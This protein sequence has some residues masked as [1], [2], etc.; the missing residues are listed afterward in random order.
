MWAGRP[1]DARA[2]GDGVDW[3]EPW[4]TLDAPQPLSTKAASRTAGRIAV[5]GIARV[6]PIVDIDELYG[7]PLDRFIP[8]RTALAKQLRAAGDRDQATVVAALKKPSA[9]AW[10]VNQLVR[11]QGQALA[12]LFDAGDALRA[13]QSDVLAGRGDSADLRAAVER[14]REAVAA[15]V[16]AGRGLLS[17]EGDGL[18]ATVLERVA[19][20]LHAA[21]LGDE[22][23]R[24]I[25]AA[26]LERE[27]R[28]VGLG[29]DTL[30]AP[31]AGSGAK[32]AG[33]PR[34]KSKATAKQPPPK[35]ARSAGPAPAASAA[36][37][38]P[39]A[40]AA[41]RPAAA[42][43][44][45]AQERRA[46]RIAEADARRHVDL[47]TRALRAAEERRDRA[48][49]ALSEAKQAVANATAE[50][51]AAAAAHARA[52]VKLKSP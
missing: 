25:S 24:A 27:L 48:A 29:V 30:S 11:T 9:A 52:K 28:H 5:E 26:R 43:K 7:L 38:A 37:A 40:T 12:E 23:R 22:A 32:P 14:E 2:I 41:A 49:E 34:G 3:T 10:A 51:R 47:T 4:I 19:D 45:R 33:K 20:S 44:E 18:S 15:L 39:A 8:E 13:A 35:A 36:T 50:A 17:S 1:P 42:A 31:A 21:A 16:D 46:A 6:A